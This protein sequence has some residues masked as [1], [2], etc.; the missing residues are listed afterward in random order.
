MKVEKRP[1]GFQ[2]VVITLET[3]IEVNALSEILN[4]SCSISHYSYTGELK[5][6]CE[7]VAQKLFDS[8]AEL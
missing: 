8:L 3:E 4:L 7:E 5:E 6:K 2:P 1:E